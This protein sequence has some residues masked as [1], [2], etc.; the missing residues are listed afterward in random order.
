ME[1]HCAES[2]SIMLDNMRNL[3]LYSIVVPNQGSVNCLN[4]GLCHS[5]VGGCV[6]VRVAG[7]PN[8]TRPRLKPQE[9]TNR[10][11]AAI[12]ESCARV[13]SNHSGRGATESGIQQ[14]G[15]IT[16]NHMCSPFPML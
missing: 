10:D 9:T 12:E 8:Q 15:E 13:N 7:V 3:T 14:S 2:D 1:D 16:Q 4:P 6:Y 11:S 5:S